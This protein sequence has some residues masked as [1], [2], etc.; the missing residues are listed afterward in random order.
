MSAHKPLKNHTQQAQP[1][2]QPGPCP[3]AHCFGRSLSLR[4]VA[5]VLE[6]TVL[7]GEEHLDTVIKSACCSDLMSDVLAFVHEKALILTGIANPHV[8]RTAEML[9]LKCIVFVRGKRPG[10]EVL[11]LAQELGVVL[12]SANKTMFVSAGLLYEA[13]VRGTPMKWASR[14]GAKQP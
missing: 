13:G 6:A 12:M 5:Q 9:D 11:E 8:L 7:T 2:A 1:G 10:E 14:E 3:D 4:E